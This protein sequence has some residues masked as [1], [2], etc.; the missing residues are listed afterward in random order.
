ML[1]ETQNGSQILSLQQLFLDS[2]NFHE[3][4][5]DRIQTTFEARRSTSTKLVKDMVWPF[6]MSELNHSWLLKENII[7]FYQAC[8]IYINKI[9]KYIRVYSGINIP[10]QAE[11]SMIIEGVDVLQHICNHKNCS[12]ALVKLEF[13]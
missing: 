6:S 3:W 8:V 2:L 12:L 10:F 4:N 1:L 7:Y 13:V 11:L 5:N 9:N